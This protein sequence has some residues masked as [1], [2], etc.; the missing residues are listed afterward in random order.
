MVVGQ[1]KRIAEQRGH[2]RLDVSDAVLAQDAET[3]L[4]KGNGALGV[5]PFGIEP[6]QRVE[7]L[8]EAQWV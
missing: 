2:R 6:T 7:T 8:G 3:L 4:Q 1:S 5:P